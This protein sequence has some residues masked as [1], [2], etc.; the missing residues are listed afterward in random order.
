M[1][2]TIASPCRHSPKEMLQEK[3]SINI[4]EKDNGRHDKY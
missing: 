2:Q 3:S 1:H 4:K